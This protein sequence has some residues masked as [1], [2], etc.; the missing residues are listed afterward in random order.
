MRRQLTARDRSRNAFYVAGR[1]SGDRGP[2]AR[3]SDVAEARALHPP[4]SVIPKMPCSRNRQFF[5]YVIPLSPHPYGS[6]E[7]TKGMR[8]QRS[9][10]DSAD[11]SVTPTTPR[12]TSPDDVL[13]TTSG[14]L[15]ARSGNRSRSVCSCQSIVRARCAWSAPPLGTIRSIS[16][17][18]RI[19]IPFWCFC[20]VSMGR[21][22]ARPGGTCTVSLTLH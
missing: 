19:R 10:P 3:T 7:E 8:M 6:E 20:P 12:S 13:G 14:C 16:F 11:R 2:D 1:E 17:I 22:G 15:R 9:K 4:N 21:L 5:P 18:R